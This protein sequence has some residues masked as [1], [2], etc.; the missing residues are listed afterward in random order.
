VTLTIYEMQWSVRYFGY[1]SRK[2]ADVV[3]LA[4]SRGNCSPSPGAIAYAKRK[5]DMWDRIAFM[6]D[7]TFTMLNNAYKSP[8]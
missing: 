3:S 6:A 7:S 5:Q 4:D 2:W 8:L 1:K